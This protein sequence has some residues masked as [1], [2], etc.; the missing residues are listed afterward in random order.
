MKICLLGPTTIVGETTVTRLGA[1]KQRQLLALLALR[2]G[3]VVSTGDITDE[4]WGAAPPRSASTAIQ[5]YI[6]QLRKILRNCFPNRPEKHVLATVDPGYVLRVQQESV[7]VFRFRESVDA[8]RRL[9]STATV[10]ALTTLSCALSMLSGPPLADVRRGIVLQGDGALVDDELMAAHQMK[11]HLEMQLG[12][13][14]S[15]IAHLR[16][17]IVAYPFVESFQVSL[18]ES[19]YRVGRRRD[20]IS[21]YHQLRSRIQDELGVDP[22]QDAK[23]LYSEIIS[24][25]GDQTSAWDLRCG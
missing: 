20:A 3:K 14:G 22:S 24:F 5:T 23:R 11:I 17:L 9:S 8:A 7:D 6:C 19:L 13:F 25:E 21:A 4:L 18:M 10:E 15:V 16:P 12:R 1:P 2:A